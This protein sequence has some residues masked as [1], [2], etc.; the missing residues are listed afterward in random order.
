MTDALGRRTLLASTALALAG[1]QGIGPDDATDGATTGHTSDDG[2]STSD[3][4]TT[5]DANPAVGTVEQVGDIALTSPEFDDGDPI[6]A[7]FS[8]DGEN[9]NPPLVVD[10]VPVTAE[11]LTMIVDDPDAESVAGEVW[12]HWL[13]WNVPAS[14]TEIPRGWEPSDG[15]VGVNDFG[16]RRYDGPDPPDGEHTYRFKCFALDGS[17]SLP[18]DA[19]KRQV[20][21]AMTDRILA[22]TQLTGTYA[23][24][25]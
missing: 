9:V 10:D 23:P 22:Q 14:T 16:N 25:E 6:P 2:T 13:V 17:L 1:C 21:E 7:A 24:S 12:L 4:T 19:S 3:A 5:A 20:G 8:R 18:D 11:T 15:T